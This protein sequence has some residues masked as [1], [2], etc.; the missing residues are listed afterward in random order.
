MDQFTE[1]IEG[2][3]ILL[4]SVWSVRYL[5]YNVDW[6]REIFQQSA[7]QVYAIVVL[8]DF[9]EEVCEVEIVHP[10]FLNLLK[11]LPISLVN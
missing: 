9:Q 4:G 8:L 2:H 10:M 6:V 11:H 7:I 3:I 1:P 5:V